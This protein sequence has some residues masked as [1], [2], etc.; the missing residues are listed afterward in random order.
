MD[1]ESII[2]LPFNDKDEKLYRAVLPKDLY[3]DSNGR[4]TSAAFRLRPKE[5]GISTETGMERTD[6]ECCE[7]ILSH[8]NGEVVYITVGSCLSIPSVSLKHSPSKHNPYHSEIVYK[9]DTKHK[10]A[11]ILHQLATYA[12][13]L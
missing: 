6:E 3:W 12:T 11:Y 13:K 1:K 5:E 2:E 10:E 9:R 8:L 7:Y 4:V